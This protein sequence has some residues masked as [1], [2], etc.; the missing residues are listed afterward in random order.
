MF[1]IVYSLI[2]LEIRD[3]GDELGVSG[4]ESSLPDIIVNIIG[5]VLS[6]IA[7][8]AVI[9]VI[10]GGFVWLTSG[11]N[12]ERIASAKRAISSAIVGIV[13]VILAWAIVSFVVRGVA[14]QNL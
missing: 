9:M 2:S 10:Y 4:G 14:N 12:D 6:F 13:I 5:Y 3:Y 11:G 7:L 8:I 1:Q